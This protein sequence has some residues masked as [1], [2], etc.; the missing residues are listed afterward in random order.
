MDGTVTGPGPRGSG[1]IV[2]EAHLARRLTK[3]KK[4]RRMLSNKPQD[5][6]VRTALEAGPMFLCY[7][8]I[9]QLLAIAL[10]L[11]RTCC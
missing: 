2:S 4:N 10:L 11:G 1:G 3:A 7:H 5:F 6:Q 8:N 9:V